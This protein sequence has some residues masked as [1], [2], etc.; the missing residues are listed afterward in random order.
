MLPIFFNNFARYVITAAR[1]KPDKFTLCEYNNN[2]PLD[3]YIFFFEYK[4]K[5][6]KL[7]QNN[8]LL[9]PNCD[10]YENSYFD[11][12]NKKKKIRI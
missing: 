3:K 10:I 7:F 4:C 1:I 5:A 2:N 8:P 11:L 9:Y 6:A 12:N